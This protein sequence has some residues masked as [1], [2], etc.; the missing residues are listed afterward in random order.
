M[1]SLHPLP[2]FLC[3]MLITLSAAVFSEPGL[4]L[5]ALAAG[6]AFAGLMRVGRLW[7]YAA[8]I[9]A[10]GAVV[11]FFMHRGET[12]LF[13][14]GDSPITLEA[15][16]YGLNV[17]A[18]L[19][20]LLVWLA[21]CNQLMDT[22]KYL[23]LLGRFT[24]RLGVML[25]MALRFLPLFIGKFK[26][27]SAAQRV[28][29]LYSSESLSDRLMNRLS[30]FGATVTWAFENG[31]TTAVSM[32]ARGFG[33]GRRTSYSLFR[34]K[35]ADGLVLTLEL[36]AMAV[37]LGFGKALKFSFF[38]AVSSLSPAVLPRTAFG[39]LC[40]LPIFVEIT[41]KIKWKYS[42]LKISASPIRELPF[43]P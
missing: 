20:V 24:P 30:V 31:V 22:E 33:P 26:E 16:L 40:L 18:M 43:R 29:G 37:L 9:P 39:I 12:A 7:F 3:L 27:I 36:L 34:F 35:T 32:E 2:A 25:T 6:L 21:C 38:P 19:A 11:P 28:M 15:L 4:T 17:G 42:A 8:I 14:M 10:V 41:E 5:A 1:K 23:Y 13:F